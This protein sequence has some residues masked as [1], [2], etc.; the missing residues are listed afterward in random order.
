VCVSVCVCVCMY[1][2]VRASVC[3]ELFWDSGR[4]AGGRGWVEV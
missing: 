1:V 4:R 3:D 2:C